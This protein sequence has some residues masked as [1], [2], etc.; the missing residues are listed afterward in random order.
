MGNQDIVASPKGDKELEAN[1][2]SLYGEFITAMNA[3][4]LQ[5]LNSSE[6]SLIR[7]RNYYRSISLKLTGNDLLPGKVIVNGIDV[8]T[9][10]AR[11]TFYGLGERYNKAV[12]ELDSARQICDE[13]GQYFVVLDKLEQGNQGRDDWGLFRFWFIFFDCIISASRG[14]YQGTIDMTD[15]KF[16]D[17]EKLMQDSIREFRR[18]NDYPF[19]HDEN[20]LAVAMVGFLN[21]MA[22]LNEQK[23]EKLEERRKRIEFMRPID[24]KVFIVHG[25][26]EKI[27]YELRDML[28]ETC[29]LEPIILK[30]ESDDGRT[31]I[32]KF[33]DYGRLCAFA[34]IIITPDD[35][36]ENKAGKYFQGRPNVLFELGWFC[37]RYGRDKVRILRKGDTALPSDLNGLIT[38]DFRENLAE[39]APRISHDLA[40]F[41]IMEEKV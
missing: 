10:L 22:D 3:M 40:S 12:E 17:E 39:V 16:V 21:K 23:L 2:Q 27:L 37:G 20:N 33:E 19:P 28:K 13:T 8:V 7:A 36:V 5:D 11:S 25:H 34:F 4:Q 41:G 38:I 32:E 29:R 14:L 1:I 6:Q 26:D 24:R 18:I 15:G 35:V 9:R 31:V 30:D